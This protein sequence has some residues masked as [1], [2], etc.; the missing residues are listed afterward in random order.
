MTPTIVD[1]LRHGEP[2]GGP[3]YRGSLDDALSLKG[4]QQMRDAI[5]GHPP[6][7]AIVSSPLRR[8]AAFATEQSHTLKIPITLEQGFQEMSFGRWEGQTSAEIMA[9]DPHQLTRFWQNPL[10]NP[11]PDGESIH[12]FFQ[13]VHRAWENLVDHHRGQTVL[14]VAHG[15]VIRMIVCLVLQVPLQHLSRVMVAYAS[16][17]RITIDT[18]EDRPMPRLLFHAGRYTPTAPTDPVANATTAHDRV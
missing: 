2:Q 8:C 18:V 14:L 12:H 4:W 11:P 16:L 6:W 1:L 9:Q 13:R 5:Q 7:N 17:S 10:E 3:K 15:G